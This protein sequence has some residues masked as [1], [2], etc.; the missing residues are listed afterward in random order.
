M[1]YSADGAAVIDAHLTDENAHKDELAKYLPLS[2][3]TMK[4]SILVPKKNS[5]PVLSN[6]DGTVYLS[7]EGNGQV[8]SLYLMNA[9]GFSS[10]MFSNISLDNN[11]GMEACYGYDQETGEFYAHS[12]I[13][14]A[15]QDGIALL[16]Q[17]GNID[18]YDEAIT[19]KKYVT[20]V[21][22][23]LRTKAHKVTLSASGWD[24][25]AKTQTVSCADVV[26][27]ETA[28]QILPMPAAASMS[29]Y[30]DAGILCTG[31]GAGTL[32]FTAETVPTADIQVFVTITPVQFS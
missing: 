20:D 15:G 23:S 26:A 21:A 27:D 7:I 18:E 28:Q 19:T 32:T 12:K 24:G 1:I 31:Q 16:Y 29:A 10:N 25:S 14:I 22:S 2:G 17:S 8:S 4:N 30:N 9:E 11:A 5:F 3:G 6:E 13:H